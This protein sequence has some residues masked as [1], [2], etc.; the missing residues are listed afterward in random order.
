MRTRRG[1][2][3]AGLTGYAVNYRNRLLGIALCPQTVSAGVRQRRVGPHARRREARE[4]RPAGRVPL[5]RGGR[6]Q[7]VDRRGQLPRQPGRPDVERRHQGQERRRRPALPRQQ[8]AR[9]RARPARGVAHGAIRRQA[10]LH[11]H[12]RPR[13]LRR[14]DHPGRGVRP[15]VRGRRPLGALPLRPV[16]PGARARRAGERAQPVRPALRQH[17]RDERVH[18]R[19]RLRHAAHGGAAPAVRHRGEHVLSAPPAA[20]TTPVVLIRDAPSWAPASRGVRRP[21]AS[22]VALGVTRR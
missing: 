12:Q 22:G 15:G 11:V 13:H 2:V 3:E 10:L 18:D 7:R 8:L 14:Q 17:G 20:P 21:A 6:L 19:E 1:P 16:R 5:L 9:L 4:R